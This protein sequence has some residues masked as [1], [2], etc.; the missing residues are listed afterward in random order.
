MLRTAVFAIVA[1]LL[2]S[3]AALAA[4]EAK[5]KKKKAAAGSTGEIVKVDA[6]K[7]TLT[8]KV[9]VKK[10]STEDKEFKVTDKTE[11][12]VVEGDA[13]TPLKADKVADLLK[14]EQ[15]KTGATVTVEAGDDGAAKSITFG[16]AMKKKK[17]KE[18]K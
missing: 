4:D 3:G 16:T 11:V 6:E 10:K 2:V 13:K 8:V 18:A 17:K 1:S 7:G 12:T 15:F 14:K 5:K 9:T